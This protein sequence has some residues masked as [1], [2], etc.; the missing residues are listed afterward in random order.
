MDF[1]KCP[2]CTQTKHVVSSHLMSAA[3]YD[4]CRPEGGNAVSFNSRLVIESSRQMQHPLLCQECEDILNKG[5]EAW[6]VPLFARLDGRFPF[7]DLLTRVPPVVVDGDAKLYAAARNPEI[8][9]ERITHFAMGIFWK[10]AVHSWRGGENDPLI[11]LGAYCEPIRKYLHREGPFPT[12]MTLTVGVL[13]PPVRHIAFTA[14]YQGSSLEP[15]N[16]LFYVLGIEFT[17][18]VGNAMREEQ[19]AASFTGNPERPIL[20][21]DFA[22]MVQDIAVEVMRK[23]HKA[24]NVQKYLKKP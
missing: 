11:E 5:G 4:Y 12:E 18:L 21:V 9:T 17:L 20:L 6:I 8:D 13:P 3:L 7:H 22:P 23:A 1:K 24:N 16:F 14:P 2:L 15:R 19:I 10:A